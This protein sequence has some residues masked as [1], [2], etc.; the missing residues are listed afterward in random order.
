M[1]RR[2]YRLLVLLHPSQFRR[3]FGPELLSIYDET[4]GRETPGLLVDGVFSL[5]RQW[6]L[7]SPFPL[8][9]AAALSAAAQILVGDWVW[10]AA[11]RRTLTGS[12]RVLNK[13]RIAHDEEML[14]LLMAGLITAALLLGTALAARCARSRVRRRT[15]TRK[16]GMPVRAMILTAAIGLWVAGGAR[17]QSASGR[18]GFEVASVKRDTTGCAGG[19]GGRGGAPQPGRLSVSCISVRDLIQAAYGT[20]ANGANPD[21]RLFQV[22]G[23][24]DWVDSDLYA[25][26]AKPAGNASID[27]MYGPMLQALLED[28]FQLRIHREVR[29]LPVY[30]LTTAKGG[31]RLK[32]SSCTPLDLSHLPGPPQA[33]EPLPVFCGRASFQSN[34]G[35]TTIDAVGLTMASFAGTTLSARVG[36]DRPVI[37]RTGLEGRFDIHLQFAPGSDSASDTANAGP[38][39]FGAIQQ[40]LGLQLSPDKGPVDVLVVDRI[41]RP[42]AN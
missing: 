16:R 28:R 36:L 4:A 29:Q 21:Q 41:E 14:L 13:T 18:P 2:L 42:S 15:G 32:T 10:L 5:L 30:T 11:V 26:E 23:L 37:D 25:I 39:L 6:A 3:S 31:P 17:A 19:H 40:Q 20:F 22:F 34:G 38:S 8:F 33:N 27:Q 12:L 7:R 24:P 9:M 35:V 1:I